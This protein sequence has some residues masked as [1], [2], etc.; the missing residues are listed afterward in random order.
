MTVP[1]SWQPG[2]VRQTPL[3]WGRMQVPVAA[4]VSSA[5]HSRPA[6]EQESAPEEA[7]KVHA[8]PM[9]I[10]PLVLPDVLVAPEVLPEPEVAPDP[11][12]APD[13]LPELVVDV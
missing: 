8:E 2:V 5:V 1:P 11:D 7:S 9:T 3:S 10:D 4:P 13:V 12:V 6:V